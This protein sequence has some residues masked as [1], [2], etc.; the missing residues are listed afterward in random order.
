MHTCPDG[1]YGNNSNNNNN[2]RL[3][4]SCSENCLKCNDDINCNFCKT[5][6]LL[7]EGKCFDK[8]P[9]YF[10]KFDQKCERCQENCISCFNTTQCEKCEENY[11]LNQITQSCLKCSDDNINCLSC[12]MNEYFCNNSCVDNCP[13]NYFKYNQTQTCTLCNISQAN[14]SKCSS[15][16]RCLGCYFPNLL[17]SSTCINSCLEKEYYNPIN[18]TCSPCHGNCS[19][20]F[21]PESR[22]C[23]TCQI[24]RLLKGSECIII[25]TNKDPEQDKISVSL[26][27]SRTNSEQFYITFS[28]EI[29][30]P[31]YF[32]LDAMISLNV[33]NAPKNSYGYNVTRTEKNDE[34][35]ISMN[36]K[37]SCINPKIEV[38]LTEMAKNYI[39]S[40]F[41]S[42]V[43]IQTL[44]ETSNF[45]NISMSSIIIPTTNK[46]EIETNKKITSNTFESLG[47]TM[48]VI[49]VFCY[50]MNT[51]RMSFFWYFCDSM[52][53]ISFFLFCQYNYISLFS[54]FFE[55]VFLYH[56]SFIVFIGRHF[57]TNKGKIFYFGH[58]LIDANDNTNFYKYLGTSSFMV[59]GF[60]AFASVILAILI[61]LFLKLFLYIYDRYHDSIANDNL[62]IGSMRYID[63]NC[64]ISFIGRISA[65]FFNIV[66][67][68]GIVQLYNASTKSSFDLV[69]LFFT[70]LAFLYYVVFFIYA[71]RKIINNQEIYEDEEH[72]NRYECFFSGLSI[73]FFFKRNHFLIIHLKKFFILFALFVTINNPKLYLVILIIIEVGLMFYFILLRP[74]EA[75]TLNVL[76]F[77]TELLI[78]IIVCVFF[79]F[80][81][82]DSDNQVNI[83][84]ENIKEIENITNILIVFIFLLLGMYFAIS[85]I[86][87]VFYCIKNI[88]CICYI[89]IS[90]DKETE[91]LEKSEERSNSILEDIFKIPRKKVLGKISKDYF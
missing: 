62:F 74:F 35:L 45:L 44:N 78:F 31:N 58:L 6:T 88:E 75:M 76:N 89:F 69:S 23:L 84:A 87:F 28:K 21:G 27:I 36:F 15:E 51:K 63:E 66:I 50:F 49:L 38:N 79:K 81:S 26:R 55:K 60:Q 82:I 47:G 32:N 56:A 39:L 7:H 25:E 29:F 4:I 10:Y 24:G 16:T 52:Q 2:K 34:F 9:L 30:L 3:C 64:M 65:F 61:C 19:K 37:E 68:S 20:C 77:L 17:N 86:L 8:C 48:I 41:T 40:Q 72:L 67:L 1:F 53:T 14:C 11:I 33:K 90:N 83:T 18:S 43:T 70:I 42:N 5:D 91:V 57:D 12:K 46:E 80:N 71:S 54:S 22:N 85:S 13:E 59:N 73:E